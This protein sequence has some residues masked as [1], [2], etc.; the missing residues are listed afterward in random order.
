[1]VSVFIT[2]RIHLAFQWTDSHD[3]KCSTSQ[4]GS[5]NSASTC[6]RKMLTVSQTKSVPL[7]AVVNVKP[8]PHVSKMKLR[9]D[10]SWCFMSALYE[11]G[12]LPSIKS[13]IECNGDV[14]GGGGIVN[15][16]DEMPSPHPKPLRV[17]QAEGAP[18]TKQ[19]QINV[20]ES[21]QA[22]S[23]KQYH[24]RSANFSSK[25]SYKKSQETRMQVMLP[26]SSSKMKQE[27][28]RCPS[29]P[30]RCPAS[31]SPSPSR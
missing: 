3:H 22:A 26:D 2:Y 28:S 5:Q 11:D 31:P 4:A 6:F 25:G 15:G 18:S 27:A 13:R 8:L 9:I 24:L 16:D 17:M 10:C 20:D 19:A 21:R 14:R 29:S 30:S 23:L 7:Q 12:H 1:M